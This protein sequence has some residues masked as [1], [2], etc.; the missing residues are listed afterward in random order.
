MIDGLPPPTRRAHP[1]VPPRRP[2]RRARRPRRRDVRRPHRRPGG[3]PPRPRAARRAAADA[4]RVPLGRHA[5]RPRRQGRRRRRGSTPSR[6]TRSTCRGSARRRACPAPPRR[7]SSC[8]TASTCTSSPR[9]RTRDLFADRQG[10]RRRHLERTTC[11]SCSSAPTADKPGY[12]EFQVNAAGHA[13]STPSSRKLRL[14]RLRQAEEGRQ[15]PHRREG[16][17]PRHAR[18][19][20]DDADKGWSV[21][22]R[23]PWT[24]FL[25]TGGRPAPGEKWKLNLCRFDYHTDWKDPE[26]SC[27]APDREEEARAVLPPDRGL[28]RRSRSSAPTRTTAK[29]FGIDEAARR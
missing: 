25:R 13:S 6:S 5:D 24:D 27:V 4:L 18:T 22:G 14:R 19:S 23:I 3:R 2:R 11:S 20:G 1:H 17:A 26:L 10:A 15:L 12:Y 7:R 28:R 16:E 8:G 21:E 9:W 29:P